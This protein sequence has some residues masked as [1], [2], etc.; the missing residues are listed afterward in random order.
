MVFMSAISAN[1]MFVICSAVN[2]LLHARVQY[3]AVT[4]SEPSA[5][6]AMKVFAKH[7]FIYGSAIVALPVLFL[8]LFINGPFF[9]LIDQVLT[10]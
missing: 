3:N 4:I 2:N 7:S 9:T 5:T 10:L 6:I 1:P 8:I